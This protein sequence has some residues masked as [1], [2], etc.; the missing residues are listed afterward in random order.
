MD[1]E[2]DAPL[3][4]AQFIADLRACEPGARL[5]RHEEWIAASP[6]VDIHARGMA[7]TVRLLLEKNDGAAGS[8]CLRLL[9]ELDKEKIVYDWDHDPDTIKGERFTSEGRGPGPIRK[10]IAR[11]LAKNPAAKNPELFAI[12]SAKPPRSWEFIDSSRQGEY[13][14]GP[15]N[16]EMKKARFMNVCGQERRKL[17]EKIT[18]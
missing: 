13:F 11:Q 12:I 10:E 18:G 6:D 7:E 8:K 2:K 9:G 14:S 3:T 4:K 17:K 15:E 1:H 16:V 5:K